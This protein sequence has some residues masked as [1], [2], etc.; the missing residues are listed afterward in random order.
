MAL[1]QT[2]D[3]LL[4]VALIVGLA[5][6]NASSTP[7]AIF[8]APTVRRIPNKSACPA[9][10]SSTGPFS[11]NW[12]VYHSIGQFESCDE[13]VFY[14][15]ALIDRVDDA[16]TNHRIY[17]C[18]SLG[19]DWTNPPA[20]VKHRATS[21]AGVTTN[22]TYSIGYWNGTSGAS[23]IA[24]AKVITPQL[25]QFLLNGFA[26]TKGP[27]ILL[28]SA[29]VSTFGLYVGE[30]LQNQAVGKFALQAFEN[31]LSSVEFHN[32]A[33]LAMQ[34]CPPGQT[35]DHVFGFIAVADKSFAK[36]QDALKSWSSGVCLPLP[37]S[38]DIT[39]LA[40]FV[41]PLLKQIPTRS[42]FTSTSAA[43][44]ISHVWHNSSATTGS[45]PVLSGGSVLKPK[46]CLHSSIIPS[47]TLDIVP[48]VTSSRITPTRSRL[49]QT[50]QSPLVSR[51]S[52]T[53]HITNA[54]RNS[55]IVSV[56]R[57]AVRETNPRR[58]VH[59]IMPRADCS[60]T[61]VVAGDG[62]ASLAQKCGISGVDFTSYNP[63][64]N[65]CAS[66]QP[67][68]HVC[69]SAGS[70]PNFAPK[71]NSDG[72]CATYTVQSNDNCANIAIKYSLTVDQLSKLNVNTWGWNGCSNIWLGTIICISTGSSPMP[73]ALAGTTCGPQVPGT[74]RPPP[75]T[76]L[77]SL[78][79][80][81][82]N[83]CCDIWGQ[84]RHPCRTAHH[85]TLS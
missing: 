34:Y 63:G 81:P 50:V 36:V 62:C 84:V 77:S 58:N 15:F 25:R 10:C 49:D 44:A 42:N 48:V 67:S 11:G 60:T 83:A 32:A 37:K 55:S 69:C 75:G 57:P 1:R 53:L 52:N 61:Q 68:Q 80:C 24:G 16:S 39:G 54:S 13:T 9:R 51:S 22:V 46:S 12:S 47:K 17:A 41:T 19:Q 79:P 27:A 40:T 82:L 4:S 43:S 7:S 8:N 26:P 45:K 31:V 23:N 85:A 6:A 35:A 72:S 76:D 28:A 38:E 56:S 3:A 70:L 5:F 66:L 18:T 64:S 14:D 2:V 71:P 65:F 59:E 29:G 73:A 33:S 20:T 74:Q 21:S 78:N 30:G